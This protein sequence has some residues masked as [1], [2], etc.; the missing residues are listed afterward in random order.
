MPL[1]TNDALSVDDDLVNY[2][3]SIEELEA[4]AAGTGHHIE[5]DRPEE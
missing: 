2:E 3:I 4:I 5:W 1:P